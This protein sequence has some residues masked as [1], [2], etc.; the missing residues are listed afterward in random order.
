M[1]AQC[2]R[3]N[4][5]IVNVKFL[6]EYLSLEGMSLIMSICIIITLVLIQEVAVAPTEMVTCKRSSY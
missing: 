6:L 1:F 5:I 3:G 2:K 4:Y